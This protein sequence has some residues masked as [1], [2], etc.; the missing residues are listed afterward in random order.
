MELLHIFGLSALAIGAG[1]SLVIQQVLNADLRTHIGSPLWAA[2]ISYLVGALTLTA[3]VVILREPYLSVTQAARTPLWSWTG[4][5]FGTVYI[6]LSIMLLP[7]LGA[8][9]TVALMIAGQMLGAMAFDHFGLFGLPEH[10][11]DLPRVAGA[12]MLIGGVLL[13]RH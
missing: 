9:T 5:V 6:V 11:A 1:T 7:R 4:G 13:V 12:L 2:L 3:V 10:K 8:A